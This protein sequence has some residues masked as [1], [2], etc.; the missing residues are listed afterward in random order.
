MRQL[1]LFFYR[2]RLFIVFL[3][4]ELVAGW[5]IF[6]NSVYQRTVLLSSSNRV[7]GNIFSFTNNVQGYFSLKKINEELLAENASLRAFAGIT[8][9]T[10]TH[11][12]ASGYVG[13][14]YMTAK[15]INNSVMWNENYITIDKGLKHGAKPGMGVVTSQGIA[16][17]VKSCSEHF[18]T[19]YSVLHTGISVSAKLKKNNTLCSV[20]WDAKDPTQARLLHLPR[21]VAVSEGDTV[22]TSGFNAVYPDGIPVGTVA[23]VETESAETFQPVLLTL[24]TDFTSLSYVY[25][26]ENKGRAERDSLEN[27]ARKR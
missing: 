7:V 25:V 21:H 24:S 1:F 2:Y 22:V 17:Q 12:P 20:Q 23:K 13:Y 5:L 10:H 19:V 18:S 16:G 6:Q 14:R 4:L 3:L 11:E 8:P 27:T 15:V 26:V 9:P